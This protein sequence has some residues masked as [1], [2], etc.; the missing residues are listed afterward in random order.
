MSFWSHSGPRG[1]PPCCVPEAGM[2]YRGKVDVWG[3]GVVAY[4]LL[5][6][7]WPYTAAVMTAQAMKAAIQLGTPPPRFRTKPGVPAVSR[8]CSEWVQALLRRGVGSRPTAK[9]ALRRR[10]GRGAL[11]DIGQGRPL[12]ARRAGRLAQLTR[13][14]SGEKVG[15]RQVSN[16]RISVAV[17]G[18]SPAKASG[19][20]PCSCQTKGDRASYGNWP[21]QF[22]RSI[23]GNLLAP[24]ILK[25]QG[26]GRLRGVCFEVLMLNRFGPDLD[27]LRL[28]LAKFGRAAARVC[29]S[30][31]NSA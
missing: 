11:G 12:V 16:P 29:P 15:P 10:M 24:P 26:F 21:C 17:F 6:G 7:A 28:A 9:A 22:S 18:T 8:P 14:C 1:S 5:F 25:L 3:L 20:L 30:L 27:R 23:F 31:T 13:A 2:P 19:I 4:V